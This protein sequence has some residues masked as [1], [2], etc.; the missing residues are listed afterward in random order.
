M[1]SRGSRW[2]RVNP[3]A[4]A[5]TSRGA[6]LSSIKFN[7]VPLPMLNEIRNQND[8]RNSALLR[9][10]S[11]HLLDVLRIDF[12]RDLVLHDLVDH[13][14]EVRTAIAINEGTSALDDFAKAP[15]DKRG[16]FKS[17]AKLFDNVIALQC[18]NHGW[19]RPK[20]GCPLGEGVTIA[21]PRAGVVGF[22]PYQTRDQAPLQS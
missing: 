18:F 3:H 10:S 1:L 12:K 5:C 4:H 2:L 14:L 13:D 17:S 16:Q 15:L 6:L 9:R 19:S 11:A 20:R 22:L 8:R 7:S 21:T